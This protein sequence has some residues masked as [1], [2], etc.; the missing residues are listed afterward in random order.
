MQFKICLLKNDHGVAINQIQK[1]ITCPDF[2]PDFLSLSAHEAVASHALPVAAAALSNFLNFYTSGKPMPI[3]EVVVLR[4]L[5][6]I[7]SQDL[8]KES[9]ILKFIKKAYTRASEIGADCFFGKGEVGKREQ[10]WFAITSW[11]F[12]TKCGKEKK[13]EL[14]A[15]FHRLVSEFYSIMVDGQVEE[16]NVM[17][18]KSLILTVAAMIASEN[19]KVTSLPDAEVQHAVELLER[20]GKVCVISFVVLLVFCNKLKCSFELQKLEHTL[21]SVEIVFSYSSSSI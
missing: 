14:C 7:L 6:T 12:G 19:Q 10:N 9:E 21:V 17:I 5:V 1:M 11:N 2:T 8:G 16:N 15:E 13:Y 3:A 20:A 18:C 4:T